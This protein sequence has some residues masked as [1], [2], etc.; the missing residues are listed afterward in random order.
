[1]FTFL[2][3]F[4][5]SYIS[6]TSLNDWNVGKTIIVNNLLLKPLPGHLYFQ[7]LSPAF[8][9]SSLSKLTPGM[10][11]LTYHWTNFIP[12]SSTS[13]CFLI[14]L[15][16][17]RFHSQVPGFAHDSTTAADGSVCAL[18]PVGPSRVPWSSCAPST[19]T[20]WVDTR[21]W[22]RQIWCCS[23][24]LDRSFEA[25]QVVQI[26]PSSRSWSH[27]DG[28]NKP[29]W[30]FRFLHID[31]LS[32]HLLPK[33]LC[34]V[35]FFKLFIFTK[36]SYALCDIYILKSF[37]VSTISLKKK[38]SSTVTKLISFK[39]LS[40]RKL[41]KQKQNTSPA[42][43]PIIKAMRAG[44]LRQT[45]IFFGLMFNSHLS[46]EV[47]PGTSSLPQHSG[48]RSRSITVLLNLFN[49]L[50]RYQMKNDYTHCNQI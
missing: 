10:S 41:K 42:L 7:T 24:R 4:S 46:P 44:A 31:S 40:E 23:R 49:G 43:N 18:S 35:S 30:Y 13:R 38:V 36:M 6:F 39:R 22:G 8:T 26:H 34:A 50:F 16:C 29:N 45:I 5:T 33:Q 17:H 25:S 12:K 37:S 9:P 11:T 48:T 20:C 28:E 21:M 47:E 3:V 1:M 2:E 14:V 19:W 15:G 27:L 32:Q